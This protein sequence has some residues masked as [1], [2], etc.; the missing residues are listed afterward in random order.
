MAVRRAVHRAGFRFRLHNWKLP[1]RP[2]L[3]LPRHRVAVL[4]HGCFWHGHGCKLQHVPRS[5]IEYWAAKIEQNTKRDARNIAL[6]THA[7]WRVAVLWECNLDKGI[8]ELIDLLR[9]TASN[10][11]TGLTTVGPF[12]PPAPLGRG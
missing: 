2:D 8:Q 12:S 11:P 3:L 6:L 5:N 1:G 9:A 4:V 10:P 7:G